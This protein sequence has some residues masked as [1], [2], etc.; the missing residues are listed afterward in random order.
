MWDNTHSSHNNV[1]Q[2]ERMARQ[3]SRA[4]AHVCMLAYT[5][6]HHHHHHHYHHTVG[7]LQE[8]VKL[9]TRKKA[10]L[11]QGFTQIL[12]GAEAGKASKE[13]DKLKWLQGNM[14]SFSQKPHFQE[15]QRP[16]VKAQSSIWTICAKAWLCRLP[17]S[18]WMFPLLHDLFQGRSGQANR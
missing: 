17:T 18:S 2:L 8:T 14:K 6:T 12:S 10:I 4:Y 11:G 7:A 16:S 3:K 5:H 15:K 9:I 13:K 1:F